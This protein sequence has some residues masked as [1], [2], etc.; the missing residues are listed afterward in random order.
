MDMDRFLKEVILSSQ[1]IAALFRSRPDQ[2]LYELKLRLQGSLGLP[3][4]SARIA[5]WGT[6]FRL[7]FP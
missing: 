6:S 3:K 1:I 5:V 4:Q 2:L 7:F